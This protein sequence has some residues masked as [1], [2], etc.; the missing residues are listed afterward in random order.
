MQQQI[1]QR[2]VIDVTYTYDETGTQTTLNRVSDALQN[3]ITD[4]FRSF[5]QQRGIALD[6]A[7]GLATAAGEFARANDGTLP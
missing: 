4:R 3:N 2:L 1:N 7:D 6:T 5:A